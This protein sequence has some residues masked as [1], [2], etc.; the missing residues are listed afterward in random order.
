MRCTA[1]SSWRR[2][3]FFQKSGSVALTKGTA[4]FNM[5][6]LGSGETAGIDRRRGRVAEGTSLLRKHTGLNLYRG[7]ESHRLRQKSKS[8]PCGVG[9]F[10]SG[11]GE[12]SACALCGWDS[13]GCAY[14][15]NRGPRDVGE[16]HRLRQYYPKSR[17]ETAF[18]ISEASR[19]RRPAANTAVP[20]AT[21]PSS[22]PAKIPPITQT[23]SLSDREQY[24]LA[25]RAFIFAI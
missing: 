7:F 15:R 23:N 20:P 8:R 25:L 13:K 2:H 11:G 14:S 6:A 5:R 1:R 12:Q 16:S 22:S 19:S 17:R 18:C 4:T 9:F 21:A 3:N 10:I 24:V